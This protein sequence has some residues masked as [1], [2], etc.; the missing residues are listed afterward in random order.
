MILLTGASGLLGWSFLSAA[1][2]RNQP[3]VGVFHQHPL[4]S[5]EAETVCVDLTDQTKVHELLNSLKPDWIVHCAAMTNVDLCEVEPDQATLLNTTVSRALAIEARKL[6]AGFVYTSTDSVFDGVRGNYS[7]QDIP[8]PINV[9]AQSKLA[10]ERAVQ[11]EYPDALIVRT[12]IYGWNV[13]RKLNLAEWILTELESQR[14]IQGF[15]DV[16]FNPLLVDDLSE[17]VLTMME[18]GMKG[19]YHVAGTGACSKYE[20]ALA[21]AEVF[22]RDG[23]LVRK[24]SVDD[25]PLK[26]PRPRNTSLNQAKIERDL[27]MKMPDLLSGLQRFKSLR[28]LARSGNPN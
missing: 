6:G 18:R 11:D 8:N 17:I 19:L 9:Y 12:N 2:R 14:S 28:P 16:I 23:Q 25:A 15:S 4:P 20:F 10:G 26:A 13:Q 21:L 27:G 1:H 24:A 22:G 5:S 3:I 7:E